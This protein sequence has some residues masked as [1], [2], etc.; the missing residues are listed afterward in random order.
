[1]SLRTGSLFVIA[2][3]IA[4]L[5]VRAEPVKIEYKPSDAPIE[6]WI[7]T[8]DKSQKDSFATTPPPGMDDW[9][10]YDTLQLTRQWMRGGDGGMIE[11]IIEPL[12]KT[13]RV[14]GHKVDSV[15]RTGSTQVRMSRRGELPDVEASGDI[16]A[17]LVPVFPDKAVDVGHTWTVDVKP[18]ASFKFPYKVTHKLEKVEPFQGS[19]TAY[20]TTEGALVTKDE[21]LA[22]NLTVAGSTRISLDTGQLVKSQTIT[23]FN[24]QAVGRFK[25]G[26][27]IQ[28]R[29]VQRIVE[30]RV[31][32]RDAAPK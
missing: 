30:R 29:Q 4:A 26:H 12:G 1:V 16:A 17:Q 11:C 32:G 20:I 31:P 8:I 28:R 2:M 25:D 27:K 22:F 5:G 24:V 3:A 10:T 6:Y 9:H 23:V 18:T 14:N 19:P 7:R 15:D 21:Q 13:V